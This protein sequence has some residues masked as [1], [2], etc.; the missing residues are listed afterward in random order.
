M[1]IWISELVVY[2]VKSLRGVSLRSTQVEKLGLRHDRRWM[3]VDEEGM[4]L[5]QR[6]LHRMALVNVWITATGL[7]IDVEGREPIDVPFEPQGGRCSVQVW[8]SIC[9]AMRVSRDADEWFSDALGLACSLVYM[10]DTTRREVAI[11]EAM[12]GDLVGFADSNPILVAGQASIDDLNARLATSIPI[13][14][15]RPNIILTGSAPYEEDGW[16]EIRI[17]EVLLRR[18]KRCARCAVPTIDIETA[19][20]SDEPL[21]ALN[22]YRKVDGKVWFGCFYAPDSLG[23]VS[24]GDGAAVR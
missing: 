12:N 7:G 21:R 4:F 23:T 9:D 10:P 8:Q 20:P 16:A 2:P 11:T 19:I 13:R 17:G 14:R 24:V 6:R 3:L 5:T 1:S 22:S 15:F 18:T